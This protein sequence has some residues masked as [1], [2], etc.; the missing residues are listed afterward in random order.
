MLG[1][2]SYASVGESSATNTLSAFV[3]AIA[4]TVTYHW[5]SEARHLALWTALAP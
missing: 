3:P 4:G 5:V 2:V 1:R